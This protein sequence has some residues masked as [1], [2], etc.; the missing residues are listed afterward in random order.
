LNPANYAAYT[1][2][3]AS[4]AGMSTP[5]VLKETICYRHREAGGSEILWGAALW[6]TL[7]FLKRVFDFVPPSRS[8]LPEIRRELPAGY[9]RS[10]P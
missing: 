10:R 2:L 1:L 7:R 9:Y 8:D 4:E 6:I 3:H 5:A